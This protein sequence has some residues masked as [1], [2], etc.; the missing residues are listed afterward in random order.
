MKM[1]TWFLFNSVIS[2]ALVQDGYYKISGKKRDLYF[3]SLIHSRGGNS[4]CAWP[5][6]GSAVWLDGCLC[7]HPLQPLLHVRNQ[8]GLRSQSNTEYW[9]GY[10]SAVD[11]KPSWTTLVINIL[12]PHSNDKDCNKNRRGQGVDFILL[13]MMG[14]EWLSLKGCLI[15][16]SVT[17]LPIYNPADWL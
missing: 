16:S 15:Y 9:K 1:D 12:V 11:Y 8:G 13:T 2:T 14:W 3:I 7:Y 6:Q 10:S 4:I 5:F 17:A